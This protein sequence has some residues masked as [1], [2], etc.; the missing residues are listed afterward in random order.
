MANISAG[1]ILVMAAVP[2][3]TCPVIANI[4][5]RFSLKSSLVL[6]NRIEAYGDSLKLSV[7][8]V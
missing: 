5:Q 1:D 6:M 4:Q 7:Y 2:R 3:T 8:V